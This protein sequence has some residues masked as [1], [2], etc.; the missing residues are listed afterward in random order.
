MVVT[1][2]DLETLKGWLVSII[3]T[4]GS[5]TALKLFDD[6][7]SPSCKIFNDMIEKI[8]RGVSGQVDGWGKRL[9]GTDPMLVCV[10]TPKGGYQAFFDQPKASPTELELIYAEARGVAQGEGLA[11]ELEDELSRFHLL[12]NFLSVKGYTRREIGQSITV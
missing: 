6:L 10:Q 2:H 7:E 11:I 3:V 9:S 12:A 1:N 8:A 4:D 5:N